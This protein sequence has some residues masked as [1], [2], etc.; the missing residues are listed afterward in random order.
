M[1]RGKVQLLTFATYFHG[2]VILKKLANFIDFRFRHVYI[3]KCLHKLA[4]FLK[5]HIPLKFCL[6]IFCFSSCFVLPFQVYSLSWQWKFFF[7]KTNLHTRHRKVRCR[8]NS[9]DLESQ[10]ATCYYERADPSVFHGQTRETP[11]SP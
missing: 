9:L 3:G 2:H 7:Q 1:K 8:C 6:R 10:I 4:T 5:Y 11:S